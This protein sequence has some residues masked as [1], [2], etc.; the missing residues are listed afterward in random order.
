MIVRQVGPGDRAAEAAAK[1]ID[2]AFRFYGAPFWHWKYADPDG[3]RSVIVVAEV[4]D[5]VVGCSHYLALD[6]HVGGGRTMSGLVGGDLF[7]IPEHRRAHVAS[8]LSLM[9]RE[10]AAS[11]HPEAAF[12]T[13]LTWRALG[14]HY[15]R[16][17]GYTRLDPGFRQWTKRLDWEGPVER[18][19]RRNPDLVERHPRLAGADHTL[20]LEIAGSPPLD[21]HVGPEG[22]T[23]ASSAGSPGVVVRVRRPGA[24]SG[25]TWLSLARA[26]TRRWITIG[27][28]AKSIREAVSVSG[29]YLEMLS[30][31]RG[32]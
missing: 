29:A 18:L 14:R 4:D 20:R 10:I 3:P 22:F 28:S 30:S 11:S 9:A 12:V 15:E 13:M 31:L 6:F 27:G 2:G 5:A 19:A 32:E 21:L 16:L 1:M 7:V 23:P 26:V 8:E 24:L 25:R 17:L